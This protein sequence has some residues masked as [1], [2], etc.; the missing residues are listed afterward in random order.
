M[1]LLNLVKIKTLLKKSPTYSSIIVSVM[2]K[3]KKHIIYHLP[4]AK[5]LNYILNNVIYDL[6]NN[7]NSIPYQVNSNVF[8]FIF[9]EKPEYF[10]DVII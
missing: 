7:I 10:E 5:N 1:I 6:I 4:K 8:D 9:H 3:E 2:N